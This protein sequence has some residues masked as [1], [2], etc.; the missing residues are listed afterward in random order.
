LYDL[1]DEPSR[2]ELT[3]D[4]ASQTLSYPGGSVSFPID[5]FNKACLL[6]GVDELG[7]IMSFEK[8]IA[9]SEEAHNY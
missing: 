3:I 7:Y 1:V 2:P 4:L 9:A 5:A 8:E 6:N